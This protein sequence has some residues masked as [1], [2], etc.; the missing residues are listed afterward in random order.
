M[1]GNGC[2]HLLGSGGIRALGSSCANRVVEVD[3]LVQTVLCAA[4]S[5]VGQSVVI[6]VGT[7][8]GLGSVVLQTDDIGGVHGGGAGVNGI[9]IHV[10]I[11]EHVLH[12]QG[13]TVGELDIVLDNKGVL[14]GVAIII[15]DNGIVLDNNSLAVT[16]GNGDLTVLVAGGQHTDL[17]HGN[18][19][20]V[21]GAGGK[22]GIEQAVQC[23]GHDN[24][25]I[26]GVCGS[27]G[28]AFLISAA[29]Q[30]RT[31]EK[32]CKAQQNAK[33]SLF[34]NFLQKFISLSVSTH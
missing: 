8:L 12:G 10:H 18:N 21:I 31:A 4:C 27:C 24:K 33:N 30:G 2:D 15:V 26:R 19:G 16:A 5:C 13:M 23:L 17:R 32:R 20:A 11:E 28:R 1:V 29:N 22:E 7:A 9:Q 25:C 6:V 34:H 3:Q 14:G